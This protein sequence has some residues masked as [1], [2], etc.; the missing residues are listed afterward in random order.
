MEAETSSWVVLAHLLRPQGRKGELLA[1]LLT[2][3]PESLTSRKE[4]YLLPAGLGAASAEPRQVE[5]VSSWLPVGKNAGRIVL[6]FAGV[7]TIS[8]AEALASLDVVIASEQRLPLDDE[9]FYVNDLEGCVLLDGDNE[10]GAVSAVQFPSSA[11]GVRIEDAAPL[12]VVH[13]P[14]SDEEILVPFVK[15]FLVKIDLERKQVVMRLPEG[16]LDVNR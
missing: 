6:Q 5:I 4:I 15:A 12:L 16:L 1:E 7:E 3:F 11:E 13:P 8:Q 9:T 2:D 10:V 14:S